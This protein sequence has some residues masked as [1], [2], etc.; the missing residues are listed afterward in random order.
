MQS[1][2][3]FAVPALATGGL[4]LADQCS[5]AWIVSRF[6]PYEARAVLVNFL[7]VVHVHN[8]GVAF[9]LLSSL[10]PK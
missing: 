9:G 6:D 10:N 3:K 8:T 7:H 1:L 2:R 4:T 5:K